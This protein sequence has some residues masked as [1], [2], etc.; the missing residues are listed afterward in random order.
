[1]KKNLNKEKTI[2]SKKIKK[3]R[4]PQIFFGLTLLSCVMVMVVNG[5]NIAGM[6]KDSAAE[7]LGQV[8]QENANKF[9]LTL[10]HNNKTWHFDK[11]DFSVNS[12][13]HTI[14]EMAQMHENNYGEYQ[15][16]L[17]YLKT[18]KNIN[19]A[20]NYLFLGLDEKIENVIKEIE[21]SPINSEI[22]FDVN[23]ENLFN[24]SDDKK[25]LKVDKNALYERINDAFLKSNN[26]IVEIPTMEINADF[27]KEKN[28]AITKK[29]SSFSI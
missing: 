6:T 22:T 17:D 26:V 11:Q 12:D 19:V 18:N 13:I 10:K 4:T 7:Y 15:Q 1:M 23:S 16:Q 14:V 8:F 27:T 2:K 20:F 3:D 25:G 28:K 24:Y 29:I 21:Y 5:Y 9:E